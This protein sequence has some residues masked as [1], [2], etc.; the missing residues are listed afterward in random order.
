MVSVLTQVVR[1]VTTKIFQPRHYS[2][3]V[4]GFNFTIEFGVRTIANTI[5]QILDM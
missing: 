4:L 2:K 3:D 5:N 1:P